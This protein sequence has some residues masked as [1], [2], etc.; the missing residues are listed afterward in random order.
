MIDDHS[1]VS[2]GTEGRV[3]SPGARDRTTDPYAAWRVEP[4]TTT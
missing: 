4:S 1:A 3:R 2:G